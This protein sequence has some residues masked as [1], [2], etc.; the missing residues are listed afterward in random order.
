[1]KYSRKTTLQS[2]VP[3]S[4]NIEDMDAGIASN[5]AADQNKIL[6]EE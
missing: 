2:K 6:L 1:M 4:T 3:N 5:D